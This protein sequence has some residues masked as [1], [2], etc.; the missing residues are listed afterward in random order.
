MSTSQVIPIWKGH[1]VAVRIIWALSFRKYNDC[2]PREQKEFSVKKNNLTAILCCSD[3][4]GRTHITQYVVIILYVYSLWP[5]ETIK[6]TLFLTIEFSEKLYRYYF[7][8]SGT[9]YYV[10]DTHK[11][12]P[13]PDLLPVTN[14][15]KEK[16]KNKIWAMKHSIFFF[17]TRYLH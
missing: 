16:C 5:I 1:Y 11:C 2:S 7:R 6:K 3:S 13:C 4:S 12:R 14:G 15:N 17:L 10:S 8:P 9:F